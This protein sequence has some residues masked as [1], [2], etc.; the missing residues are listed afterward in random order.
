MQPAVLGIP[1]LI[2]A[3]AKAVFGKG[4]D[5]K[6]LD[7]GPPQRHFATVSAAIAPPVVVAV[8]KKYP[9]STIRVFD[10]SRDA[11]AVELLGKHDDLADLVS[12]FLGP[13]E[14]LKVPSQKRVL[15]DEKGDVV[16]FGRY[17]VSPEGDDDGLLNGMLGYNPTIPLDA[18]L[19]FVCE[20][21]VNPDHRTS[22]RYIT[23]LQRHFVQEADKREA[24]L[25]FEPIKESLGFSMAR[26][27]KKL[28]DVDL[29]SLTTIEIGYLSQFGEVDR[30]Y[31]VLRAEG[32]SK[33]MSSRLFRK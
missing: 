32:V 21:G 13:A 11:L 29:E 28:V 4:G 2:S 12:A 1:R 22:T 23:T 30:D 18:P 24:D 8:D 25:V 16:G 20:I 17:L 19:L 26:I 5:K 33:L 14:S 10:E 31:L 3:D 7:V 27:C 6:T 9:V 15:Q